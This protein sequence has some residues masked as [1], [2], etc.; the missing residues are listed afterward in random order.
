MQEFVAAGT[1]SDEVFQAIVS[2]STSPVHVMNLQVI[3]DT[4]I[5]ATPPIPFEDLF[6]LLSVCTRFQS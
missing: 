4:A 3:G 5:L 1:Q 2:H 6:T